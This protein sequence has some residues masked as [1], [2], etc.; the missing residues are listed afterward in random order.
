MFTH[1]HI[2]KMVK[3]RVSWDFFS[4]ILFWVQ[5][6]FLQK[7]IQFYLFSIRKAFLEISPRGFRGITTI[8]FQ[9][10]SCGVFSEF[11]LRLQQKFAVGSSRR[12]SWNSSWNVPRIPPGLLADVFF[13]LED[14]PGFKQKFLQRFLPEIFPR[15]LQEFSF[16]RILLE[17]KSRLLLECIRNCFRRSQS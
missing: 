7:S 15:F 5:P 2:A 17:F 1:A 6:E 16:T 8:F 12:S 9:D 10:F 3:A 13:F 11:L 4:K 14:L